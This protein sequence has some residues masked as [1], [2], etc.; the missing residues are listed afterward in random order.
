MIS[1]VH[2]HVHIYMY[3]HVCSVP[4][5]HAWV[6]EALNEWNKRSKLLNLT[7]DLLGHCQTPGN[8]LEVFHTLVHGLEG[9]AHIGAK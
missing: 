3:I 4:V 1:H 7:L 8:T 9:I 5:S 6:S 2:V